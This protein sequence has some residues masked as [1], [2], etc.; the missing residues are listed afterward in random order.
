MRVERKIVKNFFPKKNNSAKKYDK[1]SVLI[2][3][4]S[5]T[6]T[7]APALSGL[8][9]L[10][11]GVDL[12]RISSPKRVADIVAGI[13]PNFI[14][15][16]LDGENLNT[17]HL[18]Y[19]L[20]VTKKMEKVSR[21]NFSV[22]LG[23]GVGKNPETGKL[24]R[25]YLKK[26]AVPIVIDADGIDALKDVTDFSGKVI[27]TPHLQE[28]TTLTGKDPEKIS[29]EE[30]K[31]MVEKFARERNITILLKG[32]EDIISDGKNILVNNFPVPELTAGGTG[33]VLAGLT[34]AF[35]S[36][37]GD[38]LKSAFVAAYIN[39]LSGK[40]TAKTMGESL[41]ATDLIEN[42]PLAISKVK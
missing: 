13:S 21:G 40:I 23:A 35:L 29:I 8:A 28:F 30:K 42:I 39:S 27:F 17:D 3:G 15:D 22:V 9:A 7:G 25:K 41:T 32:P 37:T 14:T 11:A 10:R 33:D 19:L 31:K 18:G 4:G 24:I 16:S 12:V 38:T 26:V 6:Y 20:E 5:K 34:G 2:I 1:G 36:L